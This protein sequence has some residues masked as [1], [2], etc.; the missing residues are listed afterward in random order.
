[1]FLSLRCIPTQEYSSVT[2]TFN[3]IKAIFFQGIT[4]SDISFSS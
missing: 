1:M 3:Y 2:N 4:N